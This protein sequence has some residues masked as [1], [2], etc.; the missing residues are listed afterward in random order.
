MS[1]LAQTAPLFVWQLLAD[2]LVILCCSH[3]K[4][5]SGA[6]MIIDINEFDE[7]WQKVA[8]QSFTMQKSFFNPHDFAVTEHYYVFFQNSMSFQ[9]VSLFKC[10]HVCRKAADKRKQSPPVSAVPQLH[11]VC[12]NMSPQCW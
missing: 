6:E 11:R 12:K 5:F 3:V 4:P 10:A 8:G 7:N 1:V 2:S 9:M